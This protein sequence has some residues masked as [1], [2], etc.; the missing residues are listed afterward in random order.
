MAEYL[1]YSRCEDIDPP[2]EPVPVPPDPKPSG[3]VPDDGEEGQVLTWGPDGPEWAA[4][5]GSGVTLY[6]ETGQSTTGG[7]TQK[8]ITDNLN[9]KAS[10]TALDALSATVDTKASQSD[11]DALET[12]VEG[13]VDKV[14]GKGLSSNDYTD[15]DKAIVD[16]VTSALASKADASALNN[17]YT[18]T[19]ADNLL[20]D[21]QDVLTAG[22]NI[23][24]TTDA[25]TGETVISATGGDDTFVAEYGVT[26]SQELLDY[27]ATTNEPY[28]P[29]LVKRGGA[30]YTAVI[31]TPGNGRVNLSTFGTISGEGYLFNYTVT[32]ANWSSSNIGFQTKL[33]SGTNIKT[34]NNQ[35]LL[36]SGNIDIQGGGTDEILFIHV[37]EADFTPTSTP[38][39]DSQ[40]LTSPYTVAELIDN[41]S[42]TQPKELILRIETA[43]GSNSDYLDVP[44]SVQGESGYFG[45]QLFLYE[46]TGDVT[47]VYIYNIEL[48]GTDTV[49]T[50]TVKVFDKYAKVGVET[51]TN[52][53]QS[54]TVV[55]AVY[56]GTN[57]I[58][59]FVNKDAQG[60]LGDTL[61]VQLGTQVIPVPLSPSGITVDDAL[62]ETS[63][64]PVQNR[65]IYGALE[66]MRLAMTGYL[67]RLAALETKLADF[68]E[69]RLQ[70]TDGTDMVDKVV[71]TKPYVSPIRTMFDLETGFYDVNG[72][73]IGALSD[74]GE[75]WDGRATESNEDGTTYY[76]DDIDA[77][78]LPPEVKGMVLPN[79]YGF[80]GWGGPVIA[81]A[82]DGLLDW[83][84]IPDIDYTYG[85]EHDTYEGDITDNPNAVGTIYY[86]AS[87]GLT[88]SPWGQT[89][90]TI[91]GVGEF[92]WA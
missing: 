43:S 38:G 41:A 83:V 42:Q 44:L 18:K 16:G 26:T 33:V 35:S 22:D 65:V 49:L 24:I 4:G 61:N 39:V 53:D 20:G 74:Y 66:S 3:G 51:V 29:I 13:K 30:Y 88:L 32:N 1:I 5:G 68:E 78:D 14:D 57:D 8:A 55:G 23:T 75:Y 76:I 87:T 10:Q 36:G 50:R 86:R 15:A 92:P 2:R 45:G 73:R 6:N 79:Y 67:E 46:A 81:N 37:N 11:L 40:V 70:M 54:S 80:L 27:L 9:L 60:Q 48:S 71:L 47:G 17:Y 64:N 34:I 84:V 90:A 25:Q 52:P 58:R 63:L 12:T 62:S 19:E 69:T 85:G 7:M 56:D 82:P 21:K 28:A 77:S 59:M 89:G 72:N 31:S 91:D